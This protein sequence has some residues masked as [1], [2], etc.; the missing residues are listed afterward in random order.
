MQL[1]TGECPSEINDKLDR[2]RKKLCEFQKQKSRMRSEL[3]QKKQKKDIYN[4]VY[5]KMLQESVLSVQQS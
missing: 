3:Q 1:Q 4:D 5:P 2:F